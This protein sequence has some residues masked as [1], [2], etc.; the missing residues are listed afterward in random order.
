[1]RIGALA[2]VVAGTIHGDSAYGVFD[3]VVNDLGVPATSFKATDLVVIANKLRTSDG[4]RTFRRVTELT[5]V[6][7]HWRNDPLE[8][9]GFVNLMEY[10]TDNDSLKPTD[11]LLSGESYFLNEI[12]KRVPT[13]SGRWDLVWDNVLL[14]GKVLQTILDIANQTN[15][16][17]L[18]EAESTVKSNQMFHAIAER[19]RQEIGVIDS[20]IVFN[21]WL[22]WF[23][24]YAKVF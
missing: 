11:T 6:R 4:L 10:V 19:T 3:R 7:K 12:A 14:R 15:K 2:N 1:M 17:D 23:K 18:L 16:K 22:E 21:E 24:N 5:E 8:E 9:G 13:W 20:Q